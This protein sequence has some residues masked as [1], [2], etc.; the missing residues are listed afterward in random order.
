MGDNF[1]DN[2]IKD[3][4]YKLPYPPYTLKSQVHSIFRLCTLGMVYYIYYLLFWN[5]AITQQVL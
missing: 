1:E 4:E 5:N 2:I 3:Q